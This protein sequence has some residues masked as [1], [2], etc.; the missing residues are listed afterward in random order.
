MLTV[1]LVFY[2][3]SYEHKKLSFYVFM[4]VLVSDVSIT[5]LSTQI[6]NKETEKK[7][8]ISKPSPRPRPMSLL[9]KTTSLNTLLTKER[10][11]L[12]FCRSNVTGRHRGPSGLVT[13]R[14]HY[15]ALPIYASCSHVAQ[16][17]FFIVD[18]G[19]ARFLCACMRCVCIR[20]SGIILTP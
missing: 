7:T 3:G 9:P 17:L 20:R 14:R 8:L 11:N 6:Q 1:Q 13:E 5:L 2:T 18:C 15:N 12:V 10:T 4:S 16:V 19:I